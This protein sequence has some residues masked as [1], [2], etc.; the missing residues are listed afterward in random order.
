[1][2][3]ARLRSALEVLGGFSKKQAKDMEREYQQL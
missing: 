1:M 3:R 2:V